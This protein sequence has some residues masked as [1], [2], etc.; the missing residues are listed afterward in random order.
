LQ[1]EV[2]AVRSQ[3][4]AAHE[5]IRRTMITVAKEPRTIRILPRGN[6]M[7][8]TGEIVEPAIPEFMGKL[9]TGGRRATRLDLANW[10]VDAESGVGGL[11]ARVM[12]NRFWYLMFGRG[13]APVL[14]D[15]GGQGQAPVNPELLD[16]LALEFVESGWDIKHMLKLIAMCGTYRQAST[17]T[18]HLHDRDPLNQ[19]FA[20]QSK[21][22]FPAEVIRDSALSISGLLVDR[23]DGPS[24]K[25]YQPAG[26]YRHLNFP[27]REYQSDTDDRQWRRGVYMH[28]QRQFLHPMLKAFDAPNREECTAQRPRSNTPLAAL[29]LLNDPTF[30]ESARAFATRIMRERVAAGDRAPDASQQ[31]DFAF[32]CA[33]SR[34][35][36]DE[37]QKLLQSLL[38]RSRLYY[39]DHQDEAD[40]LLAIGLKPVPD[41]L[42]RIELASWTIAARSIMSMNEALTRN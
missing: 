9:E 14:D 6:W 16:A 28:W 41:D 3:L 12:A 17:E 18:L 42:D 25:P 11:T 32:R 2:A 1:R 22:R 29:V 20:R 23:L 37:E 15:F 35:A 5:K 38:K 40:K 21:F 31:V 19:F 24:V 27:E 33:I 7:D 8:D 4:I 13:I 36:S 34:S 26:N 10:L 39:A 30:V